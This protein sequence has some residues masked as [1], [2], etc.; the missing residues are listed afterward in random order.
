LSDGFPGHLIHGVLGHRGLLEP[1][2][3]TGVGSKG[4]G[5]PT[6][7]FNQDAQG[8]WGFWVACARLA[9]RIGSRELR[10]SRWV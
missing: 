4:K 2:D 8:F 9:S 7:G 5:K 1:S 6:I 10:G 3:S